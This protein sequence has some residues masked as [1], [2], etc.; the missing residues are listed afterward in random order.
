VHIISTFICLKNKRKSLVVVGWCS[1]FVGVLN[2]KCYG[3]A[4]YEEA[5]E[6]YEG[7]EEQV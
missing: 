4:R 1:S 5:Q 7:K 6:G 2:V 3:K